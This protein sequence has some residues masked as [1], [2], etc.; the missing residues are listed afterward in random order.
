[1]ECGM[2]KVCVITGGSH[3]IGEAASRLFS[4]QGYRVYNLDL[5]PGNIGI[6]I[7]C[8]VSSPDSV[9]N[10]F[11]EIRTHEKHVDFLVISA[12]I[13]FSG[14]VEATTVAD[15]DR[16][17]GINVK[18]A[19]LTTKESLS[20][21]KEKGGSI[22]LVSSDQAFVG[23]K[24]SFVYNLSKSAVASMARTIAIDYATY[25]IRCNAICPGTIDT[26]LY[27]KALARA[28]ERLG[29]SLESLHREECSEQLLD[30]V[31]EAS[32]VAEFIAFLCSDKAG[33]VTGSLH[34]IDGGYTTL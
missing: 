30:R 23:K 33:F 16:V 7:E 31:G 20:L 24:N 29:V 25:N 8:D 34:S 11:D 15:F 3:G 13:H 12:G 32:E 9:R 1:M 2:C 18:G 6:F 14:N 4:S 26:P 17:L 28:S 27:R 10:A 19:Y 21:M 22:V 5:Q